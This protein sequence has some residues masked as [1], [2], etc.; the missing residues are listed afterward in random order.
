MGA[1]IMMIG[2]C[3]LAIGLVVYVQ[4]TSKKHKPAH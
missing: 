1:V 3:V 4:I 2:V